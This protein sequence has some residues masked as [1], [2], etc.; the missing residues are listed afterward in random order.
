MENNKDNFESNV[1]NDLFKTIVD[2][3]QEIK[4]EKIN[5]ENIKDLDIDNKES[6]EFS[7]NPFVK[8]L[9][10][11]N[12]LEF[13]DDLDLDDN[14]EGFAQ[15][16][17]HN[18]QSKAESKF[19]EIFENL[20]PKAKQLIELELK[21][22]NIENLSEDNFIDFS[23]IDLEDVDTQKEL[24]KDYYAEKDVDEKKV[25]KIIQEL[26]I[27][28]ELESEAIKAVN[29]FIEKQNAEIEEQNN[30]IKQ[31]ELESERYKEEY[32][33]DFKNTLNEID[34][35]NGFKL[36]KNDKIDLYHYMNTPV[37]RDE[38]NSTL[39]QYDIDTYNLK[40]KIEIAFLIKNNFTNFDEIKRDVKTDVSNQMRNELLKY[41]NTTTIKR[42]KSFKN[43]VNIPQF[44]TIDRL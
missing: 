36:S 6:E 37:A 27:E 19:N 38:N 13:S 40:D 1:L 2:E 42:D 35:I 39:T 23:Q 16:I 22:G 32:I 41:Q 31:K 30:L 5:E 20:S 21:G 8:S 28:E 34:E 17:E 4:S 44:S 25:N 9:V 12:I 43:T 7:F 26:E 14:E 18:I 11:N 3:N 33:E 15:L 29:Y 10:E 24:I